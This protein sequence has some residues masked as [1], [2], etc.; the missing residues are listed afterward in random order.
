MKKLIFIGLVS[1][2]AMACGG[3]PSASNTANTNTTNTVANVANNTTN[4][5]TSNSNVSNTANSAANKPVNAIAV[6]PAQSSPKRVTFA[7]GKSQGTESV[8]IG[9]GESKQFVFGAKTGQILMVEAESKDLEITLVKGKD[10]AQKKEPGY[11]D[12]TL[13]GNGDFVIQVKNPTKKEVK[14]TV[15]ILIGNTGIS[16]R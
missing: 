11:Y 1:L 6:K 15:S 4:A 2:F 14:S 3:T 5:P 7:A 8:S 10:S 9:A 13:L 16:D 12:S